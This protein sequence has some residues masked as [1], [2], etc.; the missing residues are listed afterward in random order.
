MDRPELLSVDP[1]C[2]I[3]FGPA[4]RIYSREFRGKTWFLARCACGAHFTH[5][6]PSGADIASFY[7]GGYHQG[8]V[9]FGDDDAFKKEKFAAYLAAIKPV[10][11][12]GRALDVG[13]SIGT[14][15]AL[16][17]D[18]GYQAEG[19]EI[20]ATTAAYAAR[21]HGLAIH[22]ASFEAFDES[23]GPYDVITMTDLV[24]H[25]EDPI[26]TMRKVNRLL[27]PGGGAYIRFPDVRSVKSRY[28]QTLARVFRRDWLWVTCQIPLHTIEFTR[29][30]AETCFERAGFAVAAFTREESDADEGLPTKLAPLTWP[31]RPLAWPLLA[32]R[33]GTRMAFLLRKVR[34]AN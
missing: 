20:N 34:E 4:R 29:P 22:N 5:P 10:F 16:M 13:C 28:Y 17:R 12:A 30:T 14:M 2:P 7:E 9:D 1:A 31:V 8:L 11:P 33:F 27:K 3:C 26:D 25:T 15:P 21:T 6:R 19:L 32:A 24:E 18:A 23:N